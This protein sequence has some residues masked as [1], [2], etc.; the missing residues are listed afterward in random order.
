MNIINKKY[1]KSMKIIS[2]LSEFK[3]LPNSRVLDVGCG[4]GLISKTFVNNCREIISVDIEDKRLTR[5]G[6]KFELV[7]DE[8]LP[9]EDNSFDIVIS[10]QVIEH[11]NNQDI[12]INEVCRVLKKDGVCYFYF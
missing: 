1:K 7:K 6:Y 9:F 3:D 10:N 12:H 5:E 11:V 2:I 8:K 4:K